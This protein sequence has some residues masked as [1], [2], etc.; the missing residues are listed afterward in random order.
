LDLR[1]IGSIDAYSSSVAP[2]LECLRERVARIAATFVADFY[3]TL[4][5]SVQNVEVLNRLSAQE[6]I[7][8]QERQA[9]HLITLLSPELTEEVHLLEAGRAGRAHALTGVDA[10]WLIET[11]R[12]YQQKL[13]ELLKEM[14][15]NAD[16]RETLAWVVNQRILLDIEGQLASYKRIEDEAGR[17]LLQ[18]DQLVGGSATLA[19]L[20]RGAMASIGNLEGG[21]CL[22]FA[23]VDANGELQVEA[24][25]GAAAERYH[26]CMELGTIPKISIDSRLASGQGPG[27]RAWR[28]GQIEVSDSWARDG[29]SGPWRLLGKELGF[30]S[31]AAVPLLDETGKPIALLSLYCEWPGY[32]STLRVQSF[33]IHIQRVLGNGIQRL[34]HAPVIPMREQQRYRKLLDERRL[35]MLYQP[36]VD[37]RTGQI[38][39]FEALAR[40]LG[41]RD[42]L[43]VPGRFLPA[44]GESELL[45]LFEQGLREICLDSREFDAAG[46]EL[47]FSINFPAG[48]LGD[49][50]YEQALFS[51]LEEYGIPASRMQLEVLETADADG[52]AEQNL[53]FF[54]RLRERGVRFSQ[55]DLGSGHSSLLRMGQYSF[56]EIKID[57]G[58]VRSAMQ[59]PQRALEFILYLTRLSHAFQTQVVV[60]G[61]ENLGMIEAAAILGVELGQG[62]GIARPMV[63]RDA[64]AWCPSFRY[65]VDPLYPQTALGAMAGFLLWDMQIAVMADHSELAPEILGA[66]RIVDRYLEANHL[67]E[68]ALG[69]LL[70]K[71]GSHGGGRSAAG[72]LERMQ[73]ID[74]LTDYWKAEIAR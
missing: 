30:R 23:R 66:R 21:V 62:Y 8:L 55:D 28:S 36:V 69:D 27:G 44:F 43:I 26:Q 47:P 59:K 18:V 67:Q 74:F 41:E 17:A 52:Q 46:L 9:Q 38:C 51:N 40:L 12:I 33:L 68:S 20:V 4:G 61:L 63:C 45:L 50:R 65:A 13:A 35:T 73:V 58:L 1:K 11:Y 53:A 57:Q 64:V 14:V 48:G 32:F 70:R 3:H 16:E 56:D 22:L 42:E 34:N 24:S 31:S 5:S 7:H 39:R 72:E 15:P 10:L 60:E 49:L 19:D 25:F 37:L 71:R 29:R 54:H 2:L 6:F